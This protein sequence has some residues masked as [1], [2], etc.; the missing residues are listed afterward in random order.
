MKEGFTIATLGA[1]IGDPARAN[2]LCALM[3]GRAMTAGELAREAGVGAPTASSHLAK[4]VD[5]RLL[6]V[7]IAGRHRYYRLAGHEVAE[8]IESIASLAA[9]I[10]GQDRRHGPKD[11]AM[12]KA[13]CC[14]DHLAGEMGTEL[15]DALAAQDCFTATVDGIALAPAGRAVIAALGIDVA[16][17]EAKPRPLCRVCLDWTG[18]RHHLAGSLGAAMLAHFTARGWARRDATSRA[19]HFTPPG[20]LAF[21]RITAKSGELANA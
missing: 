1:L 2:I 15:Y 4:L 20:L 21:R 8:A 19:V 7:E 16:A 12:R 10:G 14:Y 6:V 9:R 13:R 11:P 3:A 17:L 5:A 18:R